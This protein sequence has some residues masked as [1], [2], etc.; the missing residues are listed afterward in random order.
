MSDPPLHLG[1]EEA[2][3]PFEGPTQKAR[4]WTEHWVRNRLFCPSCGAP[5]LNQFPGNRPVADFY[6]PFCSE[7]FELKSKMHNF[8][9][10]VPDGAFGAMCKRLEEA[11]NP[12][13]ILLSYDPVGLSVTNLF[14]VPKHFFVR[15]VVQERRPLAPTARRAG[16]IGCNILIGEIPAAG[17]IFA[18]KDR[19]PLPKNIVLDQW[20]ATRF[21]RD[22]RTGARGWLI[23]VMKSVDLIGRREFTLGEVYAQTPRLEALYPGNRNVRPKVRQ[24]LQVLRDQGYLEFLGDGRYRLSG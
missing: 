13:L 7:E 14:F 22:E 20:Q 3:T 6:C 2:P 15:E 10:S 9:P 18:V 24:Q 19:T 4:I 21:L 16:W 12:S 8:G 5:S 11:N 17:K 23:E 1:F